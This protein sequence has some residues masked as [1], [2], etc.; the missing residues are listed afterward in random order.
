MHAPYVLNVAT[1]NN[2]IRIPSRKLLGQHADGG[3]HGR[4]QGPDRA[5]RA[6]HRRRRPGGRRRQLAQDLR[7]PGRRRRL[8]A[9]D[10]DREHRRR[11][12]RD[13]PPASTR[14]PGCGTRSASSAPA[15]AWTPVTRTPAARTSSASSTGCWRSP[16]GSILCT[17]NNCRDEF[18]S[19]ADRH[20]NFAD[21]TIDPDALVAVC[22]AA[23]APVIVETP[24]A[25][26]PGRRHRFPAR[27]A[28]VT[29]HPLRRARPDRSPELPPGED[30]LLEVGYG[31]GVGV[32]PARGTGRAQRRSVRAA[33]G[34]SAESG[35]PASSTPGW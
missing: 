13:G 7:P 27:A 3:R 8:R 9:A 18:D 19:G 14:W 29:G 33:T 10:P 28:G 15:S 20:A 21:G 25:R 6:R 1:T 24:G 22:A 11:Q 2:R 12:Q 32:A 17:L 16:A 30:R 31:S 26:R 35:S 4:R 5:R 34:P 23:G